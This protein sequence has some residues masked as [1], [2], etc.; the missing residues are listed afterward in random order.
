MGQIFFTRRQI[1]TISIF[2]LSDIALPSRL[3]SLIP[4]QILL[5]L[6]GLQRQA[7]SQNYES[8]TRNYE[9]I[10]FVTVSK[11]NGDHSHGVLYL[12]ATTADP[13]R[14]FPSRYVITVAPN[15]DLSQARID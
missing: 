10:F 15:G 2:A 6:N 7:L 8:L 3:E 14:F 9:E 11:P 12:E 4:H 13:D 1:M 5:D